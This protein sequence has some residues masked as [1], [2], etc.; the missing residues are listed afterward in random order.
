MLD[1]ALDAFAAAIGL[2]GVFEDG[3]VLPTLDLAPEDTADAPAVRLP[4]AGVLATAGVRKVGFLVCVAR[5]CAAARVED[6]VLAFLAV[7][8]CLFAVATAGLR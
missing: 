6:A 5:G 7:L 3:V 4:D 1:V 2:P 8:F